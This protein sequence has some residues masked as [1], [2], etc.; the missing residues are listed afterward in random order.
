LFFWRLP[1]EFHEEMRDGVPFYHLAP[2]PRG[3]AHNT[4][5]PSQEVEIECRKKGLQLRLRGFIEKGYTDLITQRFSVVKVMVDAEVLDIWVVWNSKSNGHNATLGA[6]GFMLDDI[7]DVKEMV[8][9]WLA[10]PVAVYLRA[11]SPPQDYSLSAGS[12][13]KSKQGD[14]DVGAMFNNFSS[15]PSERHSLGVR[16][17]HTQPEGVYERHEFWQFCALHFGGR[18]SPYLACQGQRWILEFCKSDCNDPHNHWQWETVHLNLPGSFGYDPSLPRVLL[19]RKDGELATREANYVNDIHP[20][21]REKDNESRARQA[22]A[23]LK[24][25][26]KLVG[27]QADD[28][29]Y[30]LPTS[31]PGAWN[32]VIV[33]TDTPFPMMSTTTKKWTRFKD[34]LSWI[35]DQSKDTGTVL[36]AELR[37]IP[38]LGVNIMQV[39][40]DAKCYLKGFFN[41]LEA[42]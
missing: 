10:V 22:C 30:R 26:M 14:I 21:I 28:W 37:R 13:I 7:G 27:N 33:H 29:K 4:P 25:R 11:G 12:F 36:T 40:D 39:Y 38:G 24:S 20:V 5:S 42:F 23:Q 3:H 31:T 18:P 34:G 6:P 19:L 15:H 17:I 2:P 32:G 35:I 8:I 1:R 41:A 9:K 16:V